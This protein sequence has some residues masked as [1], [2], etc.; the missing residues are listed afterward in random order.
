MSPFQRFQQGIL[1]YLHLD[2]GV[3]C[4][5]PL[6][7]SHLQELEKR[8]ILE[9]QALKRKLDAGPLLVRREGAIGH[10][11]TRVLEGSHGH[12]KA[13]V[14]MKGRGCVACLQRSFVFVW[15]WAGATPC[16]QAAEGAALEGRRG[17]SVGPRRGVRM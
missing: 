14:A 7:H 16:S 6:S 17:T 12:Q 15:P 11:E 8:G 1:C 2:S 5:F 4:F 3:G 9:K 13:V 10:G